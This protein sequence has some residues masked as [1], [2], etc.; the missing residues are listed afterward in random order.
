MLLFIWM[1]QL[2]KEWIILIKE[3]LIAINFCF[4]IVQ[5]FF[6]WYLGGYD[7]F[8]KFLLILIVV[9]YIIIIFYIINDHKS[10]SDIDFLEFTKKILIFLL[11]G[12]AHCFD[13]FL[14]KNGSVL[15]TTTIFFYIS[16]EGTTLLE[17][18]SRLGIP[19]PN[20][21]KEVLQQVSDKDNKHN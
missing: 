5:D 6:T 8:L 12:I 2:R 17:N 21:L 10:L 1:I 15:R 4:S 20:K 14:F 16:N 9:N 18:I 13:I 19:I 7:E 11:I 3:I